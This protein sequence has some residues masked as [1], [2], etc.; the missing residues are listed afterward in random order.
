MNRSDEV[1]ADGI[2]YFFYLE[3]RYVIISGGMHE[4]VIEEVPELKYPV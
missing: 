1:Q 3:C 2:R 4:V